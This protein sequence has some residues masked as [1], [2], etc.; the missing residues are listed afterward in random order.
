MIAFGSAITDPQKYEDAAGRGIALAKEPDSPV[1]ARAA[2]G[3]IYKSYNMIIDE[4]GRSGG[5][6]TPVDVPTDRLD[7]A[8]ATSPVRLST[9]GRGLQDDRAS[10]LAAAVA[11]RHAATRIPTRE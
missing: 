10:F 6:L 4:A 3:S 2:A 11:G 7:A 1:L 9:M 8:L 5:R